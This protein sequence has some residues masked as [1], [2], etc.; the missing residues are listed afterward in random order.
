MPYAGR[1]AH[2]VDN[3]AKELIADLRRFGFSVADI[4]GSGEDIP[5]CVIGREGITALLE[6]KTPRGLNDAY[7][8]SEGQKLFAENWRGS[9]ILYGH[10]AEQVTKDFIRL[11][12][13]YRGS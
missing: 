11:R 10:K 2:R 6:I 7:R 8:I 1:R 4:S 13:K 3:A 5:D 9:E 12:K